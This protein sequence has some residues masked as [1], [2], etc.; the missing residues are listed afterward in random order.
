MFMAFLSMTL[1]KRVV[2]HYLISGH[3]HMCPDRVVSHVKR[4]FGVQNLFHPNEM[5]E[6]INTIKSV[7]AQFLDHNDPARPLH[8]GW[9]KLL[10]DNM[11]PIPSMQGGGYTKAH[12]F[13]FNKG[14][15]SIRDTVDKEIK[16]VHTFVPLDRIDEV[17]DIILEKVQGHTNLDKATVKDVILPRHPICPLPRSKIESLGEKY[18]AI[19][20]E[21]LSYYPK[22]LLDDDA[23]APA[24]AKDRA[25]AALGIKKKV[26]RPLAKQ[27]GDE[28]VK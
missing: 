16:Y 14:E 15:A 19:P 13:E 17:K 21:Y 12:F 24:L 2:C 6:C 22:R 28:N 10:K 20:A 7:T 3:S 25:N 8:V 11:S 18:F 4:S 26:G 27:P 1:Y 9:D 23:N 5:V